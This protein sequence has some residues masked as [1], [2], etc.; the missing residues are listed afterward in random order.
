MATQETLDRYDEAI[1]SEEITPFRVIDLDAGGPIPG[2]VDVIL[3]A[4]DEA[5]GAS[6][7]ASDCGASNVACVV[8]ANCTSQVPCAALT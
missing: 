3:P 6:A 5:P 4:G 1:A 7:C 8:F 2:V